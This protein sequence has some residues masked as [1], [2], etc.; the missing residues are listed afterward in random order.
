MTQPG[1]VFDALLASVQKAADYNRDDMVPPAAVLWPD[2]KRE[3]ERLVPRLAG[4]VAA[5]PHPRPL[6]QGEPHRPGD[7]AAVRAGRA[8]CPTSPIAGRGRADHLPAWRQPLDPAGHRG[9][10]GRVEA[11]RRAAV[12]GR[13]LVAGERARTGPSPPSSRPTSGGLDLTIARD[14]ATATSIRRAVETAGRRAGR[15]PAGQVGRR[16]TEQP[17]LRRAGQ[18]TTSV[19]DLLRWLSD[20]KGTQGPLGGVDRWETLCS[21]C[22]ADYGFDPARDGELVGAEKLGLH[23]KAAWKTAWKRFAAAPA[24]YPGLVELLRQAK[25]QP[26]RGR[27]VRRRRVESW[28]Q[29]NEAEEADLR[30]ALLDLAASS[31]WPRPASRLLELEAEARPA[32]GVGVGEAGPVAAGPRRAAPRH[33]GRGHQD[34]PRPGRRRRTWSGPTPRAA[35]GPTPPCWTPSPP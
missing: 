8:R 15:R 13:V 9:V 4:R 27:P 16:R 34:G 5:L 6:R 35:G 2:E 3:W 30:Q 7:L 31:R 14:Q 21:R 29:D 1:T 28:P 19:D 26:K 17:V 33:P 22:P 10:P 32:A 11:A 18:S 12:P 23:E 24:R 25:P 20:P